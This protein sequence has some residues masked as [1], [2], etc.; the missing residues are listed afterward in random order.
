[1]SYRNNSKFEFYFQAIGNLLYYG[2]L[3]GGIIVL[4]VWGLLKLFGWDGENKKPDIYFY[5]YLIIAWVMGILIMVLITM[6]PFKKKNP[7]G[8]DVP[9][10]RDVPDGRD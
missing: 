5:I 9:D 7:D 3:I 8:R 4:I 2:A 1:M 6:A 10:S